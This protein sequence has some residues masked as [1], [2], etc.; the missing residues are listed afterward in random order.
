V[1]SVIPLGVVLF[2]RDEV[3]DWKLSKMASVMTTTHLL[4]FGGYVVCEA[5]PKMEVRLSLAAI[6]AVAS[7]VYFVASRKSAG[8]LNA[9]FSM[10]T[11]V[12]AF[13]IG[14]SHFGLDIGYC[15]ILAP[16]VVGV[17]IKVFCFLSAKSDSLTRT[18]KSYEM[19]ANGLVFSSGVA[20]VML[21][22]SRWLESS[23][24]GGLLF[25]MVASLV[26]A[27]I[28]SSLTRDRN[29]R[30]GYRA[31]IVAMIGSSICVLDGCLDFNS[32]HRGEVCCLVG[33]AILLGLGHLAW[34]REGE[35]DADSIASFCLFVASALIVIPLS[36]GLVYYRTAGPG[37][38][39]WR[40]FHEI[41]VIGG[42]LGLLGAGMLCRIRWTTVGGASLILVFVGSLVTLVRLPDQLQNAS[43]VMMIGGATFLATAILMSVYR[44]RLV[45]LPK[46]VADGEGVFQVLRWR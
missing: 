46:Q 38:G 30:T 31:L 7:V 24:S 27:A 8:G 34:L 20:G 5:F 42:S 29:W 14:G 18:S 25:V 36:V 41:A 15:L 37:E 13:A 12:L 39:A 21:G 35:G 3:F 19:S 26:C 40:M 23:T 4:T 9:T 44:D 33:G 1:A 11:A 32:W 22:M 10:V 45:A 17:A 16:A 43:V 6:L 28:A 2:G